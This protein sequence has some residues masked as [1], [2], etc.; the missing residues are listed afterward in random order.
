MNGDIMENKR[1]YYYKL[2][3]VEKDYKLLTKNFL[4]TFFGGGLV[5][6]LGQLILDFYNKVIGLNIENSRL[7]MTLS[8]ILITGILT[9]LGVY[10][11]LGQTFKTALAVPITGFSNA[12]ISSAIEYHKEGLVLGIG[13]N[14]LK[15]AG[16]VIVLGVTSAILVA[17]IRYLFGALV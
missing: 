13:A 5:C 2:L 14:T 8:V 11:K 3:K 15:I 12:T 17:V 1:N 10:D 6:L 16:S 9:G 4:I 7:Y